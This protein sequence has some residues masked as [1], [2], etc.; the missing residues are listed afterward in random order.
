MRGGKGD[1]KARGGE[2]RRDKARERRI[3]VVLRGGGGQDGALRREGVGLLSAVSGSL[4]AVFSA[5][6][7]SRSNDIRLCQGR[8]DVCKSRGSRG[9]SS[10]IRADM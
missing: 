8:R 5:T 1:T 2:R 4:G 3:V 6:L 10:R 9:A 7:P